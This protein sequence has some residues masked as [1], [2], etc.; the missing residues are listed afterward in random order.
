MLLVGNQWS[1]QMSSWC[2]EPFNNVYLEN[3]NGGRIAPC[4][5]AKTEKI[6]QY[7]TLY[8]QPYLQDIRKQ[9]L[10]GKQPDACV[11]C[12]KNEQQ[13]LGSRRLDK[14]QQQQKN[15]LISLEI[16]VNNRCNLKC[17][18]CGPKYSTAWHSDARKMGMDIPKPSKNNLWKE[19][20]LSKLQWVHF[21]GGEPLMSTDHAEMLEAI[22]NKQN[23]EVYYNTN[24]TIRVSNAILDLWQEFKLV[25]IV[26]SIDDV[27]ED[28]EYQRRGA[29]W[30]QVEEN[31]LWYK[32]NAP[33]NTM[34]GINRT[35]SRYNVDRLEYL[36]KWVNDV[37][38]TNRYGDTN[39]FTDQ[40]A[41]GVAG[42]DTSK[43][44]FDDYNMKLDLIETVEID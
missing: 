12:W 38:S 7:Y 32:D 25:K 9:F 44:N 29:S 20:N 22:P 36:N 35:I 6:N 10:Q 26:F 34:F 11:Q 28:F 37:F 42:L 5:M 31:M 23:C 33:H 2:S 17:R 40:M 13:G 21:N 3:L 30:K 24:G 39:D 14:G 19:L 41:L 15:S 4:C 1:G 27:A 43:Q 18:I 16:N 8:N